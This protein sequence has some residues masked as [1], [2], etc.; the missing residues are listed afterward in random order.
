MDKFFTFLFMSKFNGL[1]VDE[2]RDEN[3][4]ACFAGAGAVVW[5]LEDIWVKYFVLF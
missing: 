5:G 3:S 2:V 1:G 4:R